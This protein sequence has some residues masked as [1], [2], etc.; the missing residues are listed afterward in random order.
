MLA[1]TRV[2]YVTTCEGGVQPLKFSCLLALVCVRSQYFDQHSHLPAGGF[3]N[4]GS[5]L[6]DA[7]E[8]L[9]YGCL[10]VAGRPAGKLA[11]ASL[12]CND[13]VSVCQLLHVASLASQGMGE[14]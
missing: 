5:K 9:G 11:L 3:V 13:Q 1:G 10:G 2:W 8:F 7:F 4:F 6:N 14:F 12:A